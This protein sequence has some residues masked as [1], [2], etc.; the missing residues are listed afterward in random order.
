MFIGEYLF[1][2]NPH[3]S[4]GDLTINKHKLVNNTILSLISLNNNL[5]DFILISNIK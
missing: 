1:L 4:A 2:N 5:E 3:F